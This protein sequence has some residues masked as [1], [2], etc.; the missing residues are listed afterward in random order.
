LFLFHSTNAAFGQKHFTWH[1]V[2]TGS[3]G[4]FFSEEIRSVRYH[5]S[6]EADLPHV[7]RNDFQNFLFYVLAA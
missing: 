3:A 6:T 5:F 7:R 4:R 1:F 2:F